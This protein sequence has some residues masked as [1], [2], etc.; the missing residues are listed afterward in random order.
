[1]VRTNQK[2]N[3]IEYAKTWSLEILKY[4]R[5][6][7]IKRK[8]IFIKITPYALRSVT[9]IHC[10]NVVKSGLSMKSECNRRV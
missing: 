4:N 8:D 3:G 7:G 1:M 9:L 2:P 10:V 6:V 5:Y